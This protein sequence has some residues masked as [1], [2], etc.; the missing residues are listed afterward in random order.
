M[1]SIIV[2][3]RTRLQ[4]L[5]LKDGV[6]FDPQ[7]VLYAATFTPATSGVVETKYAYT[8]N[9]DAAVVRSGVGIYYVEQLLDTVGRM[10]FTWRST[11]FGEELN[12]EEICN[13]VAR[14]VLE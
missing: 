2:G 11:A 9:V 5:F 6:P 7:Q 3:T 1:P 8:Y 10:K 12:M 14:S 4:M 13:V